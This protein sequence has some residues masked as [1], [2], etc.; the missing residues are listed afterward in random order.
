MCSGLITASGAVEFGDSLV[1]SPKVA[2]KIAAGDGVFNTAFF[3]FD[4]YRFEQYE[5]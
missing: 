1:V 3:C 2:Q 5:F 4:K